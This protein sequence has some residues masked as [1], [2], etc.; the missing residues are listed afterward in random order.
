MLHNYKTNKVLLSLAL[1]ISITTMSDGLVQAVQTGSKSIVSKSTKSQMDTVTTITAFRARV[2][3]AIAHRADT[4]YISYKGSE[5]IPNYNAFLMEVVTTA[6][7]TAGSDYEKNLLMSYRY[8]GASTPTLANKHFSLTYGFNYTETTKQVADVKVKVKEVLSQIITPSMTEGERVRAINAYI[9]KKVAYDTSYDN[10][11]NTAYEA[12]LGSGKSKC[13]GYSLL[14]YR[15]LTEAGVQ[16]RIIIGLADG[17]H[18]WNMVKVAG[19]WYH[20][21]TTW[22]DPLPDI[23]GRVFE[24]YSLQSD[25]QIKSSHVWNRALYPVASKAYVKSNDVV[26][27]KLLVIP[28]HA[29]VTKAVKSASVVARYMSV[30]KGKIYVKGLAHGDIITV[31]TSNPNK[32]KGVKAI[33]KVTVKNKYSSLWVITKTSAKY[34]YVT[35]TSVNKLQSSAISLKNK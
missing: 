31:Y 8:D 3:Y 33:S 2:A 24:T 34:F 11:N 1:A 17:N 32:I 13:M 16:T 26:V 25:T 6:I 28:S 35:R 22:N 15:M 19:N 12:L 29:L 21:D 7:K 9:C 14:A 18:A 30:S 23:K 5:T 4:L 10:K 27:P 20:L